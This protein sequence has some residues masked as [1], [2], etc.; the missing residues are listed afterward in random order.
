[1]KARKD[2]CFDHIVT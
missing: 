1:M 2:R